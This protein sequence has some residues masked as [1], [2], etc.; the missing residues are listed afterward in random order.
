[1]YNHIYYAIEK[2]EKKNSC[3]NEIN[4]NEKIN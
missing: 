4:A 3:K 2:N 1:M